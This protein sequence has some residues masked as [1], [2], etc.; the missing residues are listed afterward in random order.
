MAWGDERD[1]GM[2]GG[3][4]PGPNGGGHPGIGMEDI[5]ADVV[6]AIAAELE[7]A[8]DA[9]V[10][11]AAGFTGYP[12]QMGIQAPAPNAVAVNQQ[13]QELTNAHHSANLCN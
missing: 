12:N 8:A 4:A 7:A 9:G 1:F 13:G 5:D 6:A 11:P 2:A 3:R 10:S